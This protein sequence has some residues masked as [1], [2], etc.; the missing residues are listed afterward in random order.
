[1]A[2]LKKSIQFHC[3]LLEVKENYPIIPS[4]NFHPT[5]AKRSAQVYKE[6][7]KQNL[8]DDSKLGTIKCPGI[9]EISSKGYI[10]TSWFDVSI[11]TTDNPIAFQYA[12][13]QQ[14][15]PY[16]E[17]HNFGKNVIKWFS[18]D[19]PQIN[20]PLP[21]HSLQTLIKIVTPWTVTVPN[22][23][24][25]LIMPIPYPDQP[26]FACTHGILESG[27]NYEINPILAIHKRPGELFIKAGTPLC[28]FIPIKHNNIDVEILSSEKVTSQQLNFNDVHRF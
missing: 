20:I 21:E 11:L 19:L 2:F 1:M 25:L 4:K 24:S 22:G 6:L 9:R 14:L 7:L 13:P 12:I 3:S 28:Q 27:D 26:E 18:G 17:E 8:L 15:T 16:L 5:W 23:W 10:L